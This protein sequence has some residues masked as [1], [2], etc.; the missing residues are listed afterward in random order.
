MSVVPLSVIPPPSAV[1]A[2]LGES[3]A[4][5][6]I[7]LSSTFIVEDEMVVVVP[8]TV[9]LPVISTFFPT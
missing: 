8:L 9:K 2:S 3:T 4:P 6:S 1:D 5:S 7:F